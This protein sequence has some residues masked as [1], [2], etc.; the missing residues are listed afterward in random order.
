MTK[1]KNVLETEEPGNTSLQQLLGSEV[2]GNSRAAER[3]QMT[4][5]LES[6]ATVSQAAGIR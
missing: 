2:T 4:V 3:R 5:P 1:Q 6:S